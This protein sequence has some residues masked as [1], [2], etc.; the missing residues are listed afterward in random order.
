MPTEEVTGAPSGREM[1]DDVEKF[2]STD[3]KSWVLMLPRIALGL[4]M[5]PHGA[6]KLLG[7]FGGYG[8]AGTMGFFTGTLHIPA[9]IA[10]LVIL[11][12]SI[13]ALMLVLGLGTRLSAI[14]ISAIMLGAVATS[15]ASH[16][17]FM[18]WAG[19]QAG[20]GFEY[21]LLALALAVPLV[22]WGGGRYALDTAL[23]ARLGRVLVPATSNA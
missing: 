7:W 10:L 17:F 9:P 22:L 23:R 19:S 2:L 3:D 4:V 8:Y 1:E 6:Q 13:G 5:F 16:G 21:H 14:G 18:N 11:G 20:E 15:H 12:E